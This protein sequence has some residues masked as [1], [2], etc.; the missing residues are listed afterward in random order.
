MSWVLDGLVVAIVVVFAIISAKRGF[1]RSILGLLS[2]VICIAVVSTY[3]KTVSDATYD[4]LLKK[5]VE[6]SITEKL[7]EHTSEVN[8]VDVVLSALPKPVRSTVES[9]GVDFNKLKGIVSTSDDNRKTAESISNDVIKPVAASM[10]L[11]IVDAVMFAAL[12]ILLRF[13]NKFVCTLFKAPVLNQVNKFL[14]V[15]LGIIKGLAIS[16]IVCSVITYI[17]SMRA[18]ANYIVFTSGAINDSL[19]FGRLAFLCQV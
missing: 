9:S 5:S 17:V 15:I 14:G 4:L 13:F 2:L 19:L 3:G 6:N 11:I 16:V 18:D 12:M 8:K 10:L 1:V 7:D